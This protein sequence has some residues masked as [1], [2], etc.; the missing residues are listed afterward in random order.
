MSGGPR[1]VEGQEKV[2]N[3]LKLGVS[4]FRT[5]NVLRP[6]VTSCMNFSTIRSYP[7]LIGM[8]FGLPSLRM[9]LGLG[10]WRS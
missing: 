4:L 7:P 9:N 10:V 1:I 3:W 2:K 5:S 8:G 6:M